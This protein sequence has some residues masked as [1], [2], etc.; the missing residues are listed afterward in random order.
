MGPIETYS[1]I[2]FLAISIKID[3]WDTEIVGFKRRLHRESQEFHW[4]IKTA[5]FFVPCPDFRIQILKPRNSPSRDTQK[6][7]RRGGGFHMHLYS[8]MRSVGSLL[9]FLD[10]LSNGPCQ[11]E[12]SFPSISILMLRVDLWLRLINK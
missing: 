2:T 12:L 3:R 8:F 7:K 5:I 1:R 11:L 9:L 10:I 6:K 4:Q